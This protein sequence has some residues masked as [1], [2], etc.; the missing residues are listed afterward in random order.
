MVRVSTPRIN[1]ISL[2]RSIEV[3]ASDPIF[4]ETVWD[5]ISSKGSCKRKTAASHSVRRLTV[6][7]GSLS[8]YRRRNE[9]CADPS[10]RRRVQSS[11]DV[12]RSFEERRLP[13]PKLG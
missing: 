3:F 9:P 12:D 2:N 11:P 8:T 13:R 5:F 10:R 1:V 7:P 6:A 4:Q